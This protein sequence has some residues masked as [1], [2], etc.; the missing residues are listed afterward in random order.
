MNPKKFSQMFY[1]DCYDK[2]NCTFSIGE[3]AN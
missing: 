2:E 3:Y 1:Q